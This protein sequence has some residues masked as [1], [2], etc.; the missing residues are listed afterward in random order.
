MSERTL[1]QCIDHTLLRPETTEFQVRKLCLEAEQYRFAN[2][3]VNPIWV[4]LCSHLL[5]GKRVG[6]CAVVG[7]PF[8]AT[9]AEIKAFEARRVLDDG[10]CEVD[11]VL[12]IGMLKSGYETVVLDDIRQV[13][14]EV[15]ERGAQLKVIIEAA[16]LADDEKVRACVLARDGGA[17]YVKT[18]TGF[19]TG[20]ATA[21]DVA[22]IRSVV[23][24]D[25]GVKAAG[26]IRDLAAVREMLAA[27]ATRIGTSAGVRIMQQAAS[28]EHS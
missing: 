23:G 26:G 27:G 9:P 8:G 20:G 14:H 24:E 17:E 7:F 28:S 12:N 1:A 11:M 13:S 25:L 16:L 22:L 2:V 5:T 10:C 3:C 18:S 6:V 15:H 21:K 4:R 19:S